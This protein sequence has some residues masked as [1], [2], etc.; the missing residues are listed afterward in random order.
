MI[1]FFRVSSLGDHRASKKRTTDKGHFQDTTDHDNHGSSTH[2]GKP[3]G[4]HAES[5]AR[6]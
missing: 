3:N 2:V 1:S 6:I 4:D 5:F